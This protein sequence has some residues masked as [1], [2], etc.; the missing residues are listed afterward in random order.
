MRVAVIRDYDKGIALEDWPEPAPVGE[1][2]VV[3]VHGAGICHTDIHLMQRWRNRPLPL[4]LG[5][6][7]AGIAPGIGAAPQPGP[8]APDPVAAGLAGMSLRSG[9]GA[10]PCGAGDCAAGGVGGCGDAPGAGPQP[11]ADWSGA[12]GAAPQPTA[13]A[14]DGPS[15]FWPS[16][17]WPSP[18]WPTSAGLSQPEGGGA[19]GGGAAMPAA[20]SQPCHC[21]DGGAVLRS[22]AAAAAAS[23]SRASIS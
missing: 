10:Q 19:A 1:E 22:A 16:Q 20:A 5:H 7:V 12:C 3:T 15:Q 21:G 9:I 14:A 2:V 4:V 13:G 6:E 23:S 8:T 11:P 17:F 18:L